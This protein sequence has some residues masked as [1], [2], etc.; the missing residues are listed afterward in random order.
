MSDK[1]ITTKRTEQTV[2][3]FEVIRE[4]DQRGYSRK[5]ICRHHETLTIYSAGCK[6]AMAWRCKV[7]SP[8]ASPARWAEY[9]WGQWH[10]T[11]PFSYGSNHTENDAKASFSNEAKMW[12]WIESMA[13]ARIDWVQQNP[14]EEWYDHMWAQS[15]E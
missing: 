5:Q 4:V 7:G 8:Y 13:P 9:E 12:S 14:M 2:G 10:V 15:I 3:Q 1:I 6:I 11:V